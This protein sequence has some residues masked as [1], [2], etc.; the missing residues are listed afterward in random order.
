MKPSSANTRSESPAP[1]GQ[2]ALVSFCFWLAAPAP[3]AEPR[4]PRLQ[5]LREAMVAHLAGGGWPGAEPLRW[6]ITAADPRRGWQ[7]EGVALL[8]GD[9]GAGQP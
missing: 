2:P 6:A 8:N 9:M 3:G 1:A 4:P 5:V 7:L